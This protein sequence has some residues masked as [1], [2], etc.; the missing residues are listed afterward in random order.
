MGQQSQNGWY[1][2]S[3]HRVLILSHWT[4]TPRYSVDLSGHH[5]RTLAS[6]ACGED[7]R[8]PASGFLDG[9]HAKLTSAPSIRE[10][11]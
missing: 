8:H 1:K 10:A 2:V 3:R 11:T 4:V 5:P 9:V 7:N 6:A